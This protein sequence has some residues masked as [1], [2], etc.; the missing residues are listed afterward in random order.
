MSDYRC[1]N[2]D[3]ACELI[4]QGAQVVDIR[5]EGSYQALHIRDAYNLNNHNLPDYVA[6][7][8]FDAPL[9]VCCYHGIS[10]QS[11]ADYLAHQ[12]FEEVY[13]LDGGFEAWRAQCPDRCES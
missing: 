11:A 8:D 2:I 1:I 6:A 9:I 10:S 7:A 5:D 12:G 3:Q 4:D 13:S